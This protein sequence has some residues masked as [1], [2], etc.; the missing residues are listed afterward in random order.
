MFLNLVCIQCS[1]VGCATILHLAYYKEL[2]R[3]NIFVVVCYL[4]LCICDE[5]EK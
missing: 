3:L 1:Q 5:C 4:L 2:L